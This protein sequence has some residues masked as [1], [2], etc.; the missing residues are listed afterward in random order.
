[1]ILPLSPAN[2]KSFPNHYK[3]SQKKYQLPFATKIKLFVHTFKKPKVVMTSAMNVLLIKSGMTK[4][5]LSEKTH[6]PVDILEGI[7]SKNAPPFY[8]KIAAIAEALGVSVDELYQK[9]E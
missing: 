8:C 1:M 9:Q 5:E 4:E 7:I 3:Q 2:D 6:I